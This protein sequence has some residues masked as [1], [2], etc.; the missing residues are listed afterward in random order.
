MCVSESSRLYAAVA[1]AIWPVS[2][3]FHWFPWAG[4]TTLF[5]K[6]KNVSGFLEGRPQVQQM[7]LLAISAK[8]NNPNKDVAFT[9]VFQVNWPN[10]ER[11][12]NQ[13]NLYTRQDTC[14]HRQTGYLLLLHPEVF[15]VCWCQSLISVR[16]LWG[17]RA[18]VTANRKYQSSGWDETLGLFLG[19]VKLR[20]NSLL[21]GLVLITWELSALLATTHGVSFPQFAFS[22]SLHRKWLW[23]G[24]VARQSWAVLWLWSLLGRCQEGVASVEGGG[25]RLIRLVNF[26]I[27][28]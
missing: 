14:V 4:R 26:L 16:M 19:S 22:C 13:N 20:W 7:H 27:W 11:P 1:I 23:G 9:N 17:Q 5:W 6:K 18:V 15:Q 25:S 2:P 10:M 24:V 12:P 3:L 21:V 28:L 8:Q